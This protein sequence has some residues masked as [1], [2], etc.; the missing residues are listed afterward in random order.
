VSLRCQHPTALFSGVLVSPV[1]CRGVHSGWR[2][3]WGRRWCRGLVP[4]SPWVPLWDTEA[5]APTPL[6]SLQ[7]ESVF[8][9]RGEAA[10]WRAESAA[11]RPVFTPFPAPPLAQLPPVP[12]HRLPFLPPLATFQDSVTAWLYRFCSI[13]HLHWL[14]HLLLL[15]SFL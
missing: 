5:L 10:T 4:K 2:G 12:E 8:P 15:R 1:S 14:P 7:E 13:L 3:F 11:Q 6:S 9:I